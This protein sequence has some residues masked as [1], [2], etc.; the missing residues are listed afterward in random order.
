MIVGIGVDVLEVER[1]QK[2]IERYNHHFLNHVFS[3]REQAEAPNGAGKATYYAGRWAAKE[4]VAKALGVGIGARCGWTEI[5]VLRGPNGKPVIQLEGTAAQTAAAINAD[6]I[7]ISIS[8]ERHLAC[9]S[10]IAEKI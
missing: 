4:A 8:H 2:T 7:H 1:M 10:A 6:T 9:A 3:S 5:H